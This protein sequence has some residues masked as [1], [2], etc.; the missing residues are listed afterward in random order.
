MS[1]VTRVASVYVADLVLVK[2]DGSEV[3]YNRKLY[4]K[5]GPAK[6]MRTRWNGHTGRRL[7]WKQLG[8]WWGQFD[9]FRVDAYEITTNGYV[10][11]P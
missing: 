4:E 9:T 11:I 2:P 10:D 8:G 1:T 7:G 3:L 5:P 6:S